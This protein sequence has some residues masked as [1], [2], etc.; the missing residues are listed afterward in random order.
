MPQI[1]TYALLGSGRRMEFSQ[2]PSSGI[3][4]CIRK[5]G[6]ITYLQILPVAEARQLW[7]QLRAD[8]YRPL[9]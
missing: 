8:V 7:Q 9:E 2:L 5:G 3:R 6:K 1:K 4:V